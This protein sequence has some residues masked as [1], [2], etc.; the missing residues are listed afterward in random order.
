MV[1]CYYCYHH[2]QKKNMLYVAK[3]IL[4]RIKDLWDNILFYVFY[5][6]FVVHLY[7]KSIQ[8]LRIMKFADYFLPCAVY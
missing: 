2:Y 1:G 5:V 7:C 6:F 4:T 8:V 3:T